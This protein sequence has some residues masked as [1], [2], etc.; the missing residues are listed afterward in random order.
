[1]L[2]YLQSLPIYDG[3]TFHFQNDSNGSPL[4]P[5]ANRVLLIEEVMRP[6]IKSKLS[7]HFSENTFLTFSI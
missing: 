7:I 3:K 4:F 1:M 5:N 2:A 6:G